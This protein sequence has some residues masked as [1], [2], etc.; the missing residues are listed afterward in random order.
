M[1]G[2]VAGTVQFGFLIGSL[3]FFNIFILAAVVFVSFV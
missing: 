2:L 3:L 1:R